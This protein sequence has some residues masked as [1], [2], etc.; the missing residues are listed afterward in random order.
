M[1]GGSLARAEKAQ[2]SAE[3]APRPN[4]TLDRPPWGWEAVERQV[5]QPWKGSR[6]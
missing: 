6:Q 5:G 4:S 2:G 3:G 1:P